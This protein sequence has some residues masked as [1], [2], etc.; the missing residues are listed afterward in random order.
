MCVLVSWALPQRPLDG[1]SFTAP[2]GTILGIMRAQSLGQG[3]RNTRLLQ[4]CARQLRGTDQDDGNDLR[5]IDVD[6]SCAPDSGCVA[7]EN[8]SV[9]RPHPR[10]DRRVKAGCELR[11]HVYAARLAAREGVYR[12]TCSRLRDPRT[13]GL[14]QSS[15]EGQRQRLAIAVPYWRPAFLSLDEAH[16]ALR[17]RGAKRSS[18]RICCGSPKAAA[19]DHFS[20]PFGCWLS[21]HRMVLERGLVY[22]SGR[23]RRAAGALRPLSR[24]LWQSANQHLQTRPTQRLFRFAPALPALIRRPMH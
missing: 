10:S 9:Q 24:D 8:V 12:T 20:Q 7:Q 22:D 4:D 14:R 13:R 6:H 21:R 2:E 16:S 11:G 23:Q 3:H 19:S 18:M 5:E 17:T 15:R 1:V